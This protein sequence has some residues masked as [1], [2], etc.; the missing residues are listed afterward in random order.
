VSNIPKTPFGLEFSVTDHVARA[1]FFLVNALQ[2]D[3]IVKFNWL[4]MSGVN[5]ARAA[6][7]I[8]LTDWDRV[9]KKG[10]TDIF[11]SD[12][13]VKIRH[14]L[15]IATIRVHDFHR[16]AVHLKPNAVMLH[17]PIKTK[18]GSQPNSMVGI[19]IDPETAKL[20]E[21]KT[22]NASIKYDRP[23]QTRGIEVY[24]FAIDTYVP[25]HVA[26]QEYLEDLKPLLTAHFP[27]IKWV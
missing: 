10:D 1:E 16:S 3:D 2:I 18:T 17:G 14:F 20:K 4:L 22:R 6:V 9:Y 8:V 15:L 25:L 24:D 7:E 11:L 13:E 26:L 23:L 5:S 19:F 21:I 27:N 12:A